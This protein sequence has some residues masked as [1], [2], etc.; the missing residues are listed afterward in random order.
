MLEMHLKQPGSTYNVSEL[1]TKY[2]E[3]TEKIKETGNSRCIYQNEL[4][5]AFVQYD[6][7]HGD[8]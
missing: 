3:R 2:K 4:D 8:F 7:S 5:K 1:F 6:M